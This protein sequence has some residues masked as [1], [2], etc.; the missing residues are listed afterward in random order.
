M[1]QLMSGQPLWRLRTG[2]LVLLS[3][4]CFLQPLPVQEQAE[5]PLPHA[6]RMGEAA[7]GF[8]CREMPIFDVPW[9]VK[10]GDTNSQGGDSIWSA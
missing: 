6:P 10:V 8:I 7:L 9:A 1:L 3:E 4:A 5:A 2:R